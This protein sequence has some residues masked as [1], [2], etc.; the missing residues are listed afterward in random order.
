MKKISLIIPIAVWVSILA[1][2]S[3]SPPS[4][5]KIDATVAAPN[6][7]PS[8]NQDEPDKK[9]DGHVDNVK[10]AFQK[11]GHEMDKGFQKTGHEIKKF[12]VGDEK[13]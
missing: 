13:K 9:D 4:V 12:F 10:E 3:K 1:C 5:I 6:S 7:N 8:P 11:T 2:E